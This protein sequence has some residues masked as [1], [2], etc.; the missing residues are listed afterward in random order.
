[1]PVEVV[2]KDIKNLHLG[3]YPPLGRV[4]I[5]VPRRTKDDAVRLAVVRKLPWIRRQQA[6]FRA[7]ERQ[8]QREM[9]SGETHYFQG[10][11]FRLR[12]KELTDARP[13]ITIQNKNI[14]VLQMSP[15]STSERR[16]SV[17]TEWY[18]EQLKQRIP[19]LIEKWSREMG[20]SPK[21]WGVRK[22]KTKWGSC[23]PSAKRIWLNL[24]LVKKPPQCLEYVLVHEMVHLLERK[25]ND[26]FITLMDRF[27]PKWRLYRAELNRAPLAHEEWEY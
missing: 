15:G 3:V 24:E 22:M 18:R 13:T 16:E 12:V 27:M 7:Q 25:H 9:L 4:R 19:R 21:F 2:R 11:R 1:M 23:N 17:L 8:S 26:R 10:Q 20:A 6:R 5:A 14:I